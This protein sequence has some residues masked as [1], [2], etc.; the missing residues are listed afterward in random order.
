MV[1]DS[2]TYLVWRKGEEEVLSISDFNGLHRE[3]QYEQ[4][5]LVFGRKLLEK[6]KGGQPHYLYHLLI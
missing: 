6:S 5:L 1:S 2:I 4:P 3:E